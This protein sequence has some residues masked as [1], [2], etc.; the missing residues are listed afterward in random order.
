MAVK[1]LAWRGLLE[2]RFR[3]DPQKAVDP[4]EL[5]RVERDVLVERRRLEERFRLGFAERKQVHAQILAAR[6]HMMPEVVAAQ[7]AYLQAE[8][9]LKTAR[10]LELLGK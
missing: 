3:F 6:Q 9:D 10:G 8:V 1:S 7:T 2:K 4:R 5:M